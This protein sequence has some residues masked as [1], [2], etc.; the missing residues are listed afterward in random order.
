MSFALGGLSDIT[1]TQ[2]SY[3]SHS[4]HG[5]FFSGLKKKN[6]LKDTVLFI[7]NF[8]FLNEFCTCQQLY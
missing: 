5:L 8:F 2:T 6:A 3:S 4:V 1:Q 7:I